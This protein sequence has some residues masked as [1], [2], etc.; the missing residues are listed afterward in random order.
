[1]MM[2]LK[3][4]WGQWCIDV[5]GEEDCSFSAQE[6][7]DLIRDDVLEPRAWVRHRFTKRYALVAEVLYENGYIDLPTFDE[8]VPK[9]VGDY[10]V[11]IGS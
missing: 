9:P 8:W 7:L 5:A 6:L 11:P 4:L 1:M 3:D 2:F 10:A